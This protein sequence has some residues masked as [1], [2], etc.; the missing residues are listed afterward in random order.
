VHSNT[1]TTIEE[2]RTYREAIIGTQQEGVWKWV[3]APATEIADR[4]DSPISKELAQKITG[5]ITLV[6]K[7]IPINTS[8]NRWEQWV[9][10]AQS[11]AIRQLG[12]SIQEKGLYTWR[13]FDKDEIIGRYSGQ[14]IGTYRKNQHRKKANDIQ[15]Y[16]NKEMLLEIEVTP[17]VTAIVDGDKA[18]PPFL[19]RANDARNLR[20]WTGGKLNNTARMDEQGRLCAMKK[21][22]GPTQGNTTR[23]EANK[24][25]HH[26]WDQL[27]HQEI[28]WAYREDL[29]R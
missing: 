17:G 18:G 22:N 27:M 16:K 6:W 24:F 26:T 20:S 5:L 9:F 13:K 23:A 14:I 8:E 2:Q 29:E 28:L 21:I 11:A 4:E 1:H 10:V 12:A 25:R 19:Q 15:K 7:H 3:S